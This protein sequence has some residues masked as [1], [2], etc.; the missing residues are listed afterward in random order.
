MKTWYID[1]SVGVVVPEVSFWGGSPMTDME[2]LLHSTTHPVRGEVTP[3]GDRPDKPSVPSVGFGGHSETCRAL[4][5]DPNRF[6][7]G[8]STAEP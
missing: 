6:D 5:D 3:P 4:P 7:L 8:C 1:R 2:C